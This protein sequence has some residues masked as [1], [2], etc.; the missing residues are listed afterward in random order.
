MIIKCAY[1]QKTEY[2]LQYGCSWLHSYG[3]TDTQLNPH[4]IFQKKKKFFFSILS[5]PIHLLSIWGVL[6][7]FQI[8][9][10]VLYTQDSGQSNPAKTY[11][12][13]LIGFVWRRYPILWLHAC[14][15][16]ETGTIHITWKMRSIFHLAICK[17]STGRAYNAITYGNLPSKRR[18]RGGDMMGCTCSRICFIIHWFQGWLTS[19]PIAIIRYVVSLFLL[20]KRLFQRASQILP[21]TTS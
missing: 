3:R 13:V 9:K 15:G 10:E 20:L 19:D 7:P 18:G 17:Y 14:K 21:N 12:S 16:L 8:G 2:V 6:H 11:V 1:L 4:E 5:L